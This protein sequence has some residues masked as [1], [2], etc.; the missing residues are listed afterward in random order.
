MSSSQIIR[1]ACDNIE[2]DLSSK[3]QTS[4]LHSTIQGAKRP[5]LISSAESLD[6]SSN[7]IQTAESVWEILLGFPNLTH[8]ILLNC[9]GID[10]DKLV[11]LF[12]SKPKLFYKLNGFI[13][14]PLFSPKL[15]FPNAFCFVT[16]S[17]IFSIL[18]FTPALVIQSLI[19][20]YERADV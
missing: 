1:V 11:N 15:T 18:Y 20:L 7:R 9:P 12:K 17:D 13:T 6:I 19:N 5:R 8:L 16:G 3:T 10:A 4:K 2:E 14:L